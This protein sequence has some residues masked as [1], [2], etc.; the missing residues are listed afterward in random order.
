M[1]P[2]RAVF[3]DLGGTLFS[4]RT[5][6][7]GLGGTMLDAAERLGAEPDRR[8][9]GRAWGAASRDAFARVARQEYYLHRDVFLESIRGFA[10]RLTGAAPDEEFCHWLYRQQRQRMIESMQLRPGCLETL[11]GLRKEGLSLSIVSNIDD[12]HLLPMVER[13]GLDSVLDH[14]TSSE[15]AGSCKPHAGFFSYCARL[16]GV[17]PGEVLFVGDSP[18]HDVGG[19]QRAGMRAALIVEDGVSPPG[20]DA[21]EPPE[22]DYQITQLPELLPIARSGSEG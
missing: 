5:V 4:Y 9:I 15:Q 20:Q 6:Q 17:E 2:Y 22:P 3:F 7:R 12:D 16:A 19:A 14:W 10:E 21:D 13:S 1:G 11:R 8:A 18:F